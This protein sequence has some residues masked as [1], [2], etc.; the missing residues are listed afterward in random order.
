MLEFGGVNVEL[1]NHFPFVVSLQDGPDNELRI[2]LAM[3]FIGEKGTMIDDDMN[4]KQIK[5]R[6]TFYN[7]FRISSSIFR[8][9]AYSP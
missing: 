4:N 5:R 7:N 3:P 9:A 1:G 8:M 6:L 2:V